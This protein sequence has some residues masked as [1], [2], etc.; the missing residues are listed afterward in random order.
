MGPKYGSNRAGSV[1]YTVKH[2]QVKVKQDSKPTYRPKN[3]NK[4]WKRH[5]Q[6]KKKKKKKE[7]KNP[8]NTERVKKMNGRQKECNQ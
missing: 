1:N 6:S 2:T 4:C 3:A 5:R 7:F 8:L